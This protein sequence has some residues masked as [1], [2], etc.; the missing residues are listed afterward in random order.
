MDLVAI[1]TESMRSNRTGSWRYLRPIYRPKTPPCNHA[2]PAGEDVRGVMALVVEGKFEQALE[3]IRED[4]PLPGVCGRVCYHPCERACNREEFDEALSIAALERLVADFGLKLPR[5][6]LVRRK[7]RIAI[8]GSG[9]AGLSCAYHLAKEG[10]QTTIFEALPV[11]GGMLRIGIPEYRLPKGVLEKEIDDILSL[12]VEVKANTRLGRDLMMEDLDGFD[13]VFIATGAHLSRRLNIPGEDADGV[14]PGLRFL[15]DFNL[16]EKVNIG[17]KV[18]VIG[19]GNTAI[20]VARAAIRLDSRPTVIYRRSR[21]EMPAIEEELREA[22]EEGVEIVHLAAP[23]RILASGGRVAMLECVKMRLGGPDGTGRREPL[24]VENSEF[25]VKADTVI[26]A[27]GEDSDLS[28]LHGYVKADA[29]GILVDRSLATS[30]K[31]VFAGGDSVTG[32]GG[33]A[34]A[35]GSGKRA[36]LAIDRYLRGE[37]LGWMAEE[38]G[39]VWFEDLNPDHFVSKKRAVMPKLDSSIRT[40][41]FDEVNL[42]LAETMGV[43]EAGR[44]FNCGECNRCD[45]CLIFCPDVA[46]LRKTDGYQIDYDHCKGCGICAEECPRGYISL[47]E[48]RR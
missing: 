47:E 17:Q 44:C 25:L 10:Y 14:V 45:N 32:T 26:P 39:V 20:D 13:A 11:L 29:S 41:N 19:G 38:T 16:G 27:V 23:N 43:E 15:K 7:E 21:E 5:E 33:V 35:I 9:P 8:V 4:N 40:D 28:F 22:E 37:P 12:G 34:E 1:S 31:G 24:P 3:L 42:G 36:A 30:R 2:C 18:V 48:E 46:I 6:G